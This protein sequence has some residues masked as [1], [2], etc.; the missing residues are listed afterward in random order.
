[1]HSGAD[2][3]VTQSAIHWRF[4]GKAAREAAWPMP[5]FRE[6][7]VAAEPQPLW[8]ANLFSLMGTCQPHRVDPFEYL[9]YAAARTGFPQIEQDSRPCF[10]R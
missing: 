3:L 1:M 9:R 5:S 8:Q 4:A 2:G 10:S 7:A 6:G